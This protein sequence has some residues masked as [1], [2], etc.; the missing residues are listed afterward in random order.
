MIN[1]ESQ[2]VFVKQLPLFLHFSSKI[3]AVFCLLHFRRLQQIKQQ[4]K[5]LKNYGVNQKQANDCLPL[6]LYPIIYKKIMLG[7]FFIY[8]RH[9]LKDFQ[10]RRH[11]F[12]SLYLLYNVSNMFKT[13]SRKVKTLWKMTQRRKKKQQN[14]QAS[15]LNVTVRYLNWHHFQ[16]NPL[17]Q[18]S[19]LNSL[20]IIP[21]SFQ[22]S[23]LRKMKNK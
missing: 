3:L 22:N 12:A 18:I 8:C 23:P 5:T 19:P 16:N 11:S 15:L 14:H 13:G 4:R 7:I 20:V 21:K 10:R 2:N 9:N 1:Q 6:R 17:Y